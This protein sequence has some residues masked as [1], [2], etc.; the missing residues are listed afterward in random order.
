MKLGG[1]DGFEPS[2]YRSHEVSV[3]YTT[4]HWSQRKDLNPQPTVYK[5]VALPLSYAGVIVLLAPLKGLE[6]LHTVPKTVALSFE[7]ERHSGCRRTRTSKPEGN[8]FTGSVLCPFA[9]TPK[10]QIGGSYCLR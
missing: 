7:L 3:H 6:P 5:T 9:Y 8:C 10:L 1:E 4:E 2:T